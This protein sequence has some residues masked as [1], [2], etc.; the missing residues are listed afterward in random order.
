MPSCL[1]FAKD[2]PDQT[3][4]I[5]TRDPRIPVLKPNTNLRQTEASRLVQNTRNCEYQKGN[6]P[7]RN[8]SSEASGDFEASILTNRT[9]NATLEFQS[10][11]VFCV[12]YYDQQLQSAGALGARS[13]AAQ[14][15]NG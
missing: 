15:Q 5:G 3:N 14:M 10:V 4:F 12:S 8:A 2:F 11:S 13:K 6:F 9:A 7:H 1:Q